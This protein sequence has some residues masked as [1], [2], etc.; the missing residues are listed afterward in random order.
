MAAREGPAARG[1][2][3]G[4]RLL[5]DLAA[6][7]RDARLQRS[8]S[9]ETAGAA[10][11]MSASQLSRF[12]RGLTT[13]VDLPQVGAL[14]GVVGLD[15]SVRAYPGGQPLRDAGHLALIAR[16]RRQLAPS[17]GWRAEVPVVPL[18]GDQ[19]AWDAVMSA[20][21]LRG[22]A[23]FETRPRDLQ[24]L[25]RRLALKARDGDVD[26]LVLV[27]AN[28]RHNRTL[29]RLHAADLAA[30]FPVPGAEALAVLGAGQLPRANAIVLV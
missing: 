20:A 19:R 3:R 17:I 4:T 28:T 12:E 16:F 21:G 5:R 1:R 18:T 6:D 11:G 23:E 27:L 30:Q 22:A 8:L 15:L 13:T 25:Q 14:C 29:I 24:E 9:L 10:V 2:A 7:I 26:V